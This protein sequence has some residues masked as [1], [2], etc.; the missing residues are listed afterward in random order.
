MRQILLWNYLK[1]QR[2]I[3]V[4]SI[5]MAVAYEMEEWLM[6]IE[7]QLTETLEITYRLPA[8]AVELPH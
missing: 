3:S 4:N 1:A 6:C 8:A 5:G 7:F 2:F